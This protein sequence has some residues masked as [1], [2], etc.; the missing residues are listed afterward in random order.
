MKD[1]LL[2]PKLLWMIGLTLFGLVVAGVRWW[3]NHSHKHTLIDELF[4]EV[5]DDISELR[6]EVKDDISKLRNEVKDDISKLRNEV[7][8]DISKLRNEV[9]DDIS[10]LRNEVKDEI[11]KLRNE[12]KDE[13]GEL[14]NEVKDDI[15]ELRIDIKTLLGRE[16][17]IADAG[18][19]L[20]LNELGK[21]VSSYVGAKGI[22]EQEAPHVIKVLPSRNPYDIQVFCKQYFAEGGTFK[23]TNDQL[24][25]FKRCAFDHGIKLEQVR[26]VCALEL[27]DELQRLI[28]SE[29]P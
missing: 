15:K 9:K 8:D 14:R 11:G 23:P 20:H 28:D 7:K 4:T 3:F 5:K 6:N 2:D 18:S 16:P 12:V 25:T 29:T 19:P 13:I 17:A 10:E 22:A 27:R 1:W 21:K 24:D 26:Y